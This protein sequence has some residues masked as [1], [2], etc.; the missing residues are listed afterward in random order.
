VPAPAWV[1]RLRAGCALVEE[2][3]AGSVFGE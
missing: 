2:Q 1:L 3:L